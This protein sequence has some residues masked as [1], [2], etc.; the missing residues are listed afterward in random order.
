MQRLIMTN[1]CITCYLKW[2]A[3]LVLKHELSF[4]PTLILIFVTSM[5]QMA[6]LTLIF[7]GQEVQ[8][9][10]PRQVD[11]EGLVPT[12]TILSFPQYTFENMY[13]VAYT[14]GYKNIRKI[15]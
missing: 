1:L 8:S 5:R 7:I 13:L 2:N 12:I 10:H 15:V 3:S 9:S 4:S 6:F 14:K 11:E